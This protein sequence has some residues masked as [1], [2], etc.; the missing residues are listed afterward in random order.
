MISLSGGMDSATLLGKLVTEQGS[1]EIH[2]CSFFYGSKHNKWEL[3]AAEELVKF[4]QARTDINFVHHQMDLSGLMSG[5]KSNLLSSGGDIPEGHYE[6]ESMKQT[7]VPGRNL[8]FISIM[9]GL[10]ESLEIDRI[11]LGV[12]SGDH[13]IYPDC[14]PDFIYAARFAIYHST[15]SR[16]HLEAPFLFM[17]K[18]SILEE[19]FSQN[20]PVPYGLTR[21]CYKD[22]ANSCGKCGSC[23][24]RLEAFKA[25][26]RVDPVSYEGE[27]D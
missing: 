23:Q 14:R 10:A 1:Q 27:A 12:H 22:Q 24:E 4:Y 20:P 2:C 16:I 25:I 21:T 6:H 8:I 18:T 3:A 13:P 5:F 9:A 11:C 19:G 7:V 26:G 15:D 17:D